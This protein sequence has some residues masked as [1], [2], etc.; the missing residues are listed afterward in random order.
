[1]Q[2][3][4]LDGEFALIK[5]LTNIIPSQSKDVLVGIGDDA[6]VIRSSN[7]K[8][9][10]LLVTTD[11]LVEGEHFKKSWGTAKQIGIKAIECNVS[12]IAAMGGV[13]TYLVISL[14]I[15]PTTKV[16]WC[17]Q[18]YQ[19]IDET[20]TSYGIVIV[21]G[22]TTQ[23][24]VETI[25]ITLLGS[26]SDKNVCLRSHAKAGDLLAVTGP[27]GASAAGLNLLKNSLPLTAYLEKKH[28]TPKCRLD[29]ALKLAPLVNAMID[30]SDGLASEVNHICNNS[31]VGATINE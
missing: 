28:L 11:I 17:E 12:D 5:K 8:D 23:A 7:N 10:F 19:G 22:D 13:P 15:P 20:C 29:A 6:A 25:N 16:E 3:K 18:L 21:G 26:V 1:M 24:P 31:H 30:I 2:I 9:M 14:A 27:L 4:D